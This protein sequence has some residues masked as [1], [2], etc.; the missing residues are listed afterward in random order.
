MTR[1]V[2]TKDHSA[3]GNQRGWDLINHL[4]LLIRKAC[5]QKDCKRENKKVNV[6]SS[7]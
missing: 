3:E 6:I 7:I 5:I 2:V 4:I 1:D